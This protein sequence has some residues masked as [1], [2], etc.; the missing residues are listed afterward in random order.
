MQPSEHVW[1]RWDSFDDVLLHSAADGIDD[2]L[3]STTFRGRVGLTRSCVVR[4]I[5]KSASWM[6]IIVWRFNIVIS[7]IT[8]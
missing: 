7:C 5:L 2:G 4:K 1:R 3:T 6:V 8:C